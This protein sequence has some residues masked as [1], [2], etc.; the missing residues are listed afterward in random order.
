LE[1]SVTTEQTSGE[2]FIV[3]RK[4][5]ELK[6][7]DASRR[8]AVVAARG[9]CLGPWRIATRQI[10]A[11]NNAP[12]TMAANKRRALATVDIGSAGVSRKYSGN[13]LTGLPGSEGD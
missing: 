4:E 11:R 6:Q 8:A 3:P 12:T 2:T 7:A 10:A 5:R 9:C 1:P 13:G